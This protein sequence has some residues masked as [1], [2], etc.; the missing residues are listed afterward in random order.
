M[1]E[2]RDEIGEDDKRE[3]QLMETLMTLPD[4]DRLP[5]PEHF[6]KK[7]NIPKPKILGLMEALHL[8]NRTECL[9]GDG[10]P[11]EIRQ[12]AS[13]G[14][15]PLIEVEPVKMEVLKKEDETTNNTE[16]S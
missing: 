1:F 3:R 16:S 8:Q 13:G 9:P 10:R 15:R 2:S 7:Y 14:V 5:L 6:Y 12:P 4:F 11:I